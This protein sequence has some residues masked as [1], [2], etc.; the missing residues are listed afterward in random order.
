MMPMRE[1]EE[2]IRKMLQLLT[3]TLKKMLGGN[4]HFHEW[5]S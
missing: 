2:E 1:T 4:K 3:D 5:S